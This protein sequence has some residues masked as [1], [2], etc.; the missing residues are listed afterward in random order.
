MTFQ[1]SELRDGRDGDFPY[2][3]VDDEVDGAAPSLG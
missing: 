3:G 1:F 2:R